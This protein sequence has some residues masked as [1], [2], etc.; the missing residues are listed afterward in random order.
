[1]TKVFINGMVQIQNTLQLIFLDERL[2]LE[3]LEDLEKLYI[4]LQKLLEE[5]L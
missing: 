1:M 5:E 4:I 3:R 2:Y